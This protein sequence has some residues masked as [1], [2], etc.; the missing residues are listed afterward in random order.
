MANN[1][2]YRAAERVYAAMTALQAAPR[3]TRALYA[4]NFTFELARRP[5][6]LQSH[7]YATLT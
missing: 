3:D 5:R 4:D 2:Y 6:P 7:N 1:E